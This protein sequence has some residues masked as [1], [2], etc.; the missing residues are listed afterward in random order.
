MLICKCRCRKLT[1]A[2]TRLATNKVVKNATQALTEEA[3]EKSLVHSCGLGGVD[4]VAADGVVALST[5]SVCE[6]LLLGLVDNRGVTVAGSSSS[7]GHRSGT[8][9]GH[10][11]GGEESSDSEELHF[12]GWV[13]LVRCFE[14][15]YCKGVKL[16]E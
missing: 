9:S 4:L 16:K 1:T 10:G 5:A 13:G 8:R 12:D 15:N 2:S 7:T 14:A 6:G 11:G 3:T